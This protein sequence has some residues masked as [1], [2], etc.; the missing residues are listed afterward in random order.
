MFSFVFHDRACCIGHRD[1]PG[2]P[3]LL[4]PDPIGMR[5]VAKTAICV[6]TESCTLLYFAN[7]KK[8]VPMDLL[9]AFTV[10]L[11]SMAVC[12]TTGSSMLIA[13]AI[14]LFCFS[15]VALRRGYA[16]RS[17]A[18]MVLAS[19]K[20]SF[21]VLRILLLIGLVTALWRSGGTIAFFVYY[22]IRLITPGLFIFI[23]FVLSAILSYALGT[24]FGVAGTAG[25]IFMTLARSGGVNELITAGAVISGAYFGDR[26]AP[27]SS[28]ANLVATVT[29]TRLYDNVRLMLKTGALPTLFTLL[30]FLLLSLR[31]PISV[32]DPA[33]LDA[34]QG[35]FDLSFWAVVPALLML[36]LPLLGLEVRWALAAS[37]VSSF[38]VTVLLQDLSVWDAL[39]AAVVGY[40]PPSGPL[41]SILSGGGVLSMLNVTLIVF[42]SGTF[43]G[44]F[45]GT[46]MLDGVQD[47]IGAV[48]RKIGLFPTM[49]VTSL[50][51]CGAFCNQTIATMLNA[52]LLTR[53]YDGAGASH[54]ELAM[55]I[56]NSVVTIAG[57]IPWSVACAVP[58][59][60]LGASLSAIPYCLL[61]WLIPLCYGLTRRWFFPPHANK[62]NPDPS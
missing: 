53:V 48:A 8:T 15:A 7:R 32:V 18:G 59:Q 14:G 45:E 40:A 41:S 23:T 16:L 50:A 5:G 47:K 49:L 36:I 24:S 10:F 57:L 38:A 51:T 4:S 17:V 13:L 21:I 29:D 58:L 6:Y 35:S 44:V 31:N 26:C 62:E 52:Q 37:I 43:S 25:V 1:I 30:G 42:L 34:L 61:L 3:C 39:K 60:M 9:I 54:T 20:K 12:L 56:S 27:S 28:C 19:T 33:I 55:D 22:G 46:H 11:V 2:R